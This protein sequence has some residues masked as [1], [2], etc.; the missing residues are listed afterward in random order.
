MSLND[1]HNV[2]SQ[3]ITVPELL[4][5]LDARR[6][7]AEAALAV[8]LDELPSFERYLV[9]GALRIEMTRNSEDH[10]TELTALLERMEEY[11]YYSS[12]LQACRRCACHAIFHLL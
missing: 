5:Y 7:S 1:F 9:D 3:V 12:R 4:A 2:A 6:D 8:G 10:A 11:H